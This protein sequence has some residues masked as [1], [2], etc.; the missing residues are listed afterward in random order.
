MSTVISEGIPVDGRIFEPPQINRDN[1]KPRYITFIGSLIDAETARSRPWTKGGGLEIANPCLRYVKNFI[2]KGRITPLLKDTH[3]FQRYDYIKKM[4]DSDPLSAGYFP[5]PI[6]KGYQPP[7]L[8]P[9][10]GEHHHGFGE[11]AVGGPSAYGS[12]IG[13]L[14]LPG[15][16]I[17]AILNGAENLTQTNIQRGAVELTVLRGQEY[18]PQQIDGIY[19]DPNVWQMQRTIFPDYPNFLDAN[20]NPT[21]LLDDMERLLDAA[22]DHFG[23]REIVDAMHESLIQFRDYASATIQNV[24]H[25]MKE[26]AGRGGY[27]FRYTAMDLILLEQ[28]GQDRQDREI[29]QQARAG[30]NEKMEEMFQRFMA[31]QIEEKEANLARMN[32]VQ[33]PIIDQNTMAAAPITE[34]GYDGYPG[35][36]GYSGYSG[37]VIAQATTEST[38][39]PELLD[40]NKKPLT[41][42][43]LENRLKK[44]GRLPETKTEE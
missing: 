17:N 39:D 29:R 23:L 18:R 22:V 20:G 1:E 12:L 42:F 44:L 25:T 14:A 13:R 32:R 43:A 37:E 36:S 6:P 41:G 15:E 2:R 9:A 16:Q 30:G 5:Q 21:V 38:V 4:T 24:H 34:K 28:L 31:L 10:A 7:A 40:K 3:D 8:P 35:Q 11:L 19:V 27:V 26:S 33:E